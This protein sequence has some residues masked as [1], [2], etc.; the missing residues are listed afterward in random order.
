MV[1]DSSLKEPWICIGYWITTKKK[2]QHMV[3]M[4]PNQELYPPVQVQ[5]NR[6]RLEGVRDILKKDNANI[7]DNSHRQGP[8]K[9][10]QQHMGRSQ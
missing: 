8:P 5:W 9:S 2:R 7:E 4:Q 1:L 6:Q 3:S 10:L